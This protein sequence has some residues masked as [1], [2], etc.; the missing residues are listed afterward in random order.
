MEYYEKT[1]Q[2][3]NNGYKGWEKK[4]SKFWGHPVIAASRTAV[5]E[6]SAKSGTY[7]TGAANVESVKVTKYEPDDNR[8][9]RV[10]MDVCVD[11]SDV[12]TFEEDGTAIRRSEGVPSRYM[13]TYVM[14]HQGVGGVWTVN[15]EERHVGQAC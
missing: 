13:F 4:L 3:A 9:E 10:T 14:L 2:V 7:T 6:E 12:A 5:Y 8:F 1:A 15:D 11:F